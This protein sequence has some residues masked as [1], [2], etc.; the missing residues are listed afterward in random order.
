MLEP[1]FNTIAILYDRKRRLVNDV[2]VCWLRNVSV[3][4]AFSE[5]VSFL[6]PHASF[7]DH[8]MAHVVPWKYPTTTGGIIPWL[9]MSLSIRTWLAH[10]YGADEIFNVDKTPIRKAAFRLE[11]P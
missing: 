4:H 2:G 5:G 7:A 6:R 3:N 9:V 10:Y 8:I 1:L 11:V